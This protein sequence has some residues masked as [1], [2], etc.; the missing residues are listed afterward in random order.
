MV[1]PNRFLGSFA[2]GGS[3][4]ARLWRASE[5]RAAPDAR[6]VLK[7]VRDDVFSSFEDL[8]GVWSSCTSLR[9]TKS[10]EEASSMVITLNELSTLTT[11]LGCFFVEHCTRM[12]DRRDTFAFLS[13]EGPICVAFAKI[14]GF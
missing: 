9:R 8:D 11:T 10:R 6:N 2:R 1:K 4:V 5:A 3:I 12:C 13:I 14:L 7:H